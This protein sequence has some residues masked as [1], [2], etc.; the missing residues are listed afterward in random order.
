MKL[1][2]DYVSRE[3]A[4]LL[5]DKGF[6][7]GVDLRFTRNLSYYDSIGLHYNIN[8]DYNSLILD[9]IDFVIAPTLQMACNWLRIV[10]HID[11]CAFPEHY[12]YILWGY[13]CKIYKNKEQFCC[14]ENFKLYEEAVEAAIKYCLEKLI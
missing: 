11:I 13:T 7:K 4:K 1:T 12:D 2:E 10:H 8:E 5:K 3:V 9:K 14:L 6:L